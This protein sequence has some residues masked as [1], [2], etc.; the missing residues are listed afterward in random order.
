MKLKCPYMAKEVWRVKFAEES[1][2]SEI[3][4]IISKG[5]TNRVIEDA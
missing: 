1:K 3:H 4:I 2:K 5:S